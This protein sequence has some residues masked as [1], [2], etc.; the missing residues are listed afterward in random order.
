MSG[1]GE[2]VMHSMKQ[3]L[4][5]IRRLERLEMLA[6]RVANIDDLLIFQEQGE[7]EEIQAM[8]RE[9]SGDD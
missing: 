8:A 5:S 7:W 1:G 9:L 3:Q 6:K 2:A 4:E